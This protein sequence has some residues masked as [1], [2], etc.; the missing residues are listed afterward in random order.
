M[1]LFGSREDVVSC[2]F[3]PSS[4]SQEKFCEKYKTVKTFC[5]HKE[6][7][8]QKNTCTFCSLIHMCIL[9]TNH[10]FKGI[11]SSWYFPGYSIPET[12]NGVH[13]PKH[14]M[15]TE[16]CCLA[17]L[18]PSD[19]YTCGYNPITIHA[20]SKFHMCTWCTANISAFCKKYLQI[21]FRVFSLE[22][23]ICR[24]EKTKKVN[25]ECCYWRDGKLD[26]T[27]Q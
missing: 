8:I 21:R 17:S 24:D 2:V 12:T 25:A 4:E 11:Q 6:I 7:W 18:N 5:R 16:M 13:R 26:L 14:R 15:D 10:F 22:L 27:S 20:I 19:Y 3:T 23:S 9:C 1:F